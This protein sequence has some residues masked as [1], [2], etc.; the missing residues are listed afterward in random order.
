MNGIDGTT[1][2][3][4]LHWDNASCGIHISVASPF[5]SHKP[6]SDLL[7]EFAN[8]IRTARK[9]LDWHIWVEKKRW[10]VSSRHQ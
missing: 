2:M 9:G 1:R 7:I 4:S 8:I 3:S 5:C 6:S 10:N